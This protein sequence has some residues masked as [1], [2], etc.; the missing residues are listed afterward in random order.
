VRWVRG[1]RS[2]TS[3]E[4][5]SN[6]VSNKMRIHDAGG[7]QPLVDLATCGTTEQREAAVGALW[8]LAFNDTNKRA[9]AAAGGIPPLVDL[10]RAGT[11]RQKEQAAGALANLTV[12]EDNRSRVVGAGGI[13]AL[14]PLMNGGETER[15]RS[16]AHACLQ[17]LA[18][19]SMIKAKIVV[20][21]RSGE[22]T[23]RAQALADA[24]RQQLVID[25][26]ATPA[27]AEA[28]GSS[29]PPASVD[30]Q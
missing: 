8:N 18:I 17:N 30:V 15:Q 10:V 22:E 21:A 3:N 20:T 1:L 13:A 2:L 4:V 12:D 24:C 14:V 6:G 26:D 29:A 27:K 25:D 19:D 5:G 23:A 7:I 28:A 9:I 11:P 16:F